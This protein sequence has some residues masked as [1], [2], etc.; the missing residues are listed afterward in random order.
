[1]NNEELYT[2]CP[3][4]TEDVCPVCNGSKFVKAGVSTMQLK[5]LIDGDM[6]AKHI[7]RYFESHKSEMDSFITWL[8]ENPYP[9]TPGT[10]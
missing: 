9:E 10:S 7:D 1:M 4:C 5:Y 2:K 8:R 6:R 3:M